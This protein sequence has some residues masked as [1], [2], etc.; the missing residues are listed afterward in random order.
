MSNFREKLKFRLD[1]RDAV[2]YYLNCSAG[3][4]HLVERHL[5]K[6]EVASSSLVARSMLKQ[7]IRFGCPVFLLDGENALPP[8][9]RGAHIR[10]EV[11]QGSRESPQAVRGM[12]GSEFEPRRPLRVGA[13]FVS[14]APTFLQKSERTHAAA[15]PFQ[16]EPAV[17]GFDLVSG[18]NPEAAASLLFR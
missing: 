14:L 5:A 6:V 8:P 12:Q 17:L 15:P 9:V 13:S 18:V 11:R 7:D 3:V 1:K 16:I 4:A 2:W 10:S